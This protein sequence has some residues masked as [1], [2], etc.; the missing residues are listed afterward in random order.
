MRLS[1]KRKSQVTPTHVNFEAA[2]ARSWNRWHWATWVV[3]VVMTCLMVLLNLGETTP[4][5]SKLPGKTPIRSTFVSRGFPITFQDYWL[6]GNSRSGSFSSLAL[7]V[8]CLV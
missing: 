2:M 4:H 5:V 1:S 3:A 7:V 8:D 6:I